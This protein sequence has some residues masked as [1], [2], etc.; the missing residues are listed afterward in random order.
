MSQE[1]E[2][3]DFDFDD[4][5]PPDNAE[6]KGRPWWQKIL[7]QLARNPGAIG[8]MAI[9]V[10][11]FLKSTR[12]PAYEEVPVLGPLRPGEV[13]QTVKIAR[14]E[15]PGLDIPVMSFKAMDVAEVHAT[16]TTMLPGFGG[17]VAPIEKL[18][19]VYLKNE[20]KTKEI[21]QPE[22]KIWLSD[23]L[24]IAGLGAIGGQILGGFLGK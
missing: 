5:E 23:L 21:E 12:G 10:G 11:Y 17:L 7:L 16:I 20:M 9:G 19:L 15:T 8:L 6:E 2:E 4:T 1:E 3:E 22:Y 18:F 13:R 24:I 14:G